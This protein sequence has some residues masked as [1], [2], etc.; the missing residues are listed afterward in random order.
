MCGISGY[1]DLKN[2]VSVETLRQMNDVIRHRGPDDEGYALIGACGAFLCGGADT[3]PSLN[4]PPLSNAFLVE[5]G[6]F[7]GLGHR[8]LSIL[9]LSPS[10]HQPMYLPAQ[11]LALVYNGEIYNYI[12]LRQ[13]LE[14]LGCR[15]HS[16]SDTEV[17]LQAYCVWGEDCL[18]HF[19]G[20]WSFALWDGRNKKLFC[21][22]D[23]LGAKP[24]HYWHQGDKLIF[25]SELKQL[26]Q[27]NTIP[28]RFNLSYL[29][30]N[31]MYG[32]S[33][34]NDQTLVEGMQVLR[35][36]HQMTVQLDNSLSHIANVTVRPY[37]ELKVGEYEPLSP[38]QWQEKVRDEF[39]RSV[40]WR[41]R[42]DAPLAALLSGGLDSSCLVTEI[43]SQLDDPAAFQTF[44]TSYPGRTDCDEWAFAD[45]VNRRCGCQGHQIFPDPSDDIAGRYKR[46]IWSIEGFGGP[47]LLGPQI[48][49]EEIHRRGFKVILNGQCGD[50]TML[51]YERYYTYYFLDLLKQ[52][53]VSEFLRSFR[54][55]SL[56]SALTLPQ[57]FAMFFYF[58]LP[59]VR[60]QRQLHR[61]GQFVRK[62][63]LAQ[64]KG[65]ELHPLLYHDSLQH[66]QKTELTA[67]QLTHIVRFDDRQCMSA[68]IESRIPFMDY[69]F[70]ELAVQIPPSLKIQNGYTKSIMRELFDARMP[71]EVTWRT[72]KMGFGAPVDRWAAAFPED[73][74][75]ELLHTAK[76]AP[77][78]R[79]DAL[80]K[81]V[82]HRSDRIH[83]LFAFVQA[84][85]FARCFDVGIS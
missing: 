2:G 20:M 84:E 53:K 79:I 48:L 1:L 77:F 69:R 24:F 17:L 25:G 30:A 12:E 43:C 47:A 18:S 50:E 68:S 41:L 66:L 64:R 36:G 5:G 54:L 35:P 37:W 55:A 14:G 40:R 31:L 39:S 81:A 19:N 75:Y 29:S 8:R 3:D 67:T 70:V 11:Q 61:T 80:E 83:S 51:G 78:F 74:L 59:I 9:D 42:S 76:T 65:A 82:P 21:A 34:Y 13:E 27:D 44:T 46:L 58:N 10:G 71:K 73:Y 38:S 15:F 63:L 49:L 22:R 62:E 33:D 4:L 7:L 6:A 60:D 72:N 23:R 85:E 16:S 26:C 56:H 32:L 45:M 57:L 28:R 52:G